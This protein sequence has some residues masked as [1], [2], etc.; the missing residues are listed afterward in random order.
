MTKQTLILLRIQHRMNFVRSLESEMNIF[1]KS[2]YW[3]HLNK[4][5][6]LQT[7]QNILQNKAA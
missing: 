7:L 5:M 1:Q 4:R 3:K 2:K 6:R